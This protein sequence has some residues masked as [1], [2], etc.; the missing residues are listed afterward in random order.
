MTQQPLTEEILRRLLVAKHL[1]ASNIGQLTPQSDATTVASMILAAH[2]AAE[3]AAA[4]ISSHLGVSDLPEQSFLMHYP[5]RIATKGGVA[6]PG[7]DFLRQLNAARNAFKHHGILPDVRSWYRV[8]ETTWNR[9]DQWCQTYLGVSIDGVDLEQMLADPLVKDH[10]QKA[11]RAHQEQRYRE[12]LEHLG[13]ALLQVL[14]S[15]PGPHWPVVDPK[16]GAN[17]TQTALMLTAFGVRAS[18]FLALQAFLP[19]VSLDFSTNPTAQRLEWDK[20]GR[21]HSGNWTDQNVRF[22]LETFLDLALKVQHAPQVPMAFH[23][24]MIFNDVITPKGLKAELFEYVYDGLTLITQRV[25]DRRTVMTI[26]AGEKLQCRLEPSQIQEKPA[27]P[28]AGLGLLS[29]QAPSIETADVLAVYLGEWPKLEPGSE[30]L[31]GVLY[32][33]REAVEVLAEPRDDPFVRE[34]CP[35]LF[36]D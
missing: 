31:P 36:P 32:V 16:G 29:A 28:T 27:P 23:F 10:Y 15:L 6:F 25:I 19:R 13:L 11:K 21:G 30:S 17:A 3:L 7:T 24:A 1:L 20:R 35:H 4:A 34:R 26:Q 33:D 14:R 5:S 12:A 2:D 8:V 22:C 9:I 18:D